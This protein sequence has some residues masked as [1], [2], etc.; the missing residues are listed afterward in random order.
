M[1]NRLIITLLA[2]VGSL[3]GFAD[4]MSWRN[5]P[6][7]TAGTAVHSLF[8]DKNGVILIGSNN[9][10]YYYDGYRARRIIGDDDLQGY[11]IYGFAQREDKL[12]LGT[13]NGLRVSDQT[14]S[15]MRVSGDC[16]NEIRALTL[17]GDSLYIGSLSGLF[18]YDLNTDQIEHS[19]LKLPHDAVYALLYQDDNLYIGT[20]GGLC[21]YNTSTK[22]YTTISLDI[23]D[24]QFVNSL[25]VDESGD[26]LFL[27]MEGCLVEYDL[28]EGR[29]INRLLDG[30]SVKSLAWNATQ[31]IVGTD[32][33][34]YIIK[35]GKTYLYRHNSRNPG[36]LANNI[37]WALLTDEQGNIIAGSENGLSIA[38]H[39][40]GIRSIS[41]SDLTGQP[42]GNQIYTILR[43]AQDNLW[44]GGS[45]GLIRVG[46][47]GSDWFMP[48]D[49]SKYISHNRIRD[50]YQ[51]RSG[52]IW[53]ATDGSINR[54][55]ANSRTFT[56]FHLRDRSNRHKADWAYNIVED[57]S[58]NL[59]VG[60][61]LGGVMMVS[62][63]SLRTGSA[64]IAQ[65][66]ITERS[67]LSNDFVNKLLID[68]RDNKWLL[69]FRDSLLTRINDSGLRH[70]DI[71]AICGNY[72]T[73]LS[74][75]GLDALWVGAGNKIVR[76][77]AVTSATEVFSL[78]EKNENEHISALE[79]IGS[80]VWIVATSG[81]WALD[82]QSGHVR[83]LPLPDKPYTSV[84]YDYL[85]GQV[86][87]GANDEI[88]AV[89]TQW[90]F[91]GEPG[92]EIKV[93]RVL[94]NGEPQFDQS[95]FSGANSDKITLQSA[96]DELLIELSTLEYTPTRSRRFAYFIKGVTDDFVMLDVGDNTLHLP[97]LSPG[98]Y[99][100][101]IYYWD[102]IDTVKR[103]AIEVLRP[104]YISNWAIFA[105]VL[106]L[107]VGT[108][109][110]IRYLR[111]RMQRRL[112]ESRR[113]EAM[114]AVRQKMDF[115]TNISHDLKTP[116]SM[117][118]GPV[119]RLRETIESKSIRKDLNVI[120]SNA[121]K[122]NEMIQRTVEIDR[123]DIEKEAPL[124]LSKVNVTEFCKSI[125]DSY[126][127]THPSVQF[128]FNAD[129]HPIFTEWDAVKIE[130]VINNLLSNACKYTQENATIGFSVAEVEGNI[131]MKVS[132]DG[133]GIPEEE[134][135]L[136]FQRM[137]RSA[138]TAEQQ[139][140]TGI[141]LYLVKHYVE[142][143]NGTVS[144]ESVENF[145]TTFTVTIPSIGTRNALSAPASDKSDK[146]EVA[147]SDAKP[148]ILIVEDNLTIADFIKDIL[149]D[150]YDCQI[151]TNGRAGISLLSTYHPDLIIT[152][153]MMPVMS[154]LEMCKRI[155]AMPAFAAIPIIMVTAKDDN[156]TETESAALGVD[157]F[158]VKP[159]EA[160]L[161]INIV[162]AKIKARQAMQQTLRIEQ[163]TA[164]A[165][166]VAVSPSEKQ[167]DLVTRT[168]EKYIDDSDLNV[169]FLCEKTDF[170]AKQLYRLIKKYV[171]VTPIEYIRQ[172]RLRKAAE[173]LAK[174]SFT[175]SEVMYMVG[176]SSPS[177]FSK[178]FTAL[179]GVPPGKYAE[180]KHSTP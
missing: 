111:Q 124:I 7:G 31:L 165:P 120:Y 11:Q 177:Y 71:R 1:C 139:T 74:Y 155:K 154:G 127:E 78:P 147:P 56:T 73:A 134:L 108:W 8:M 179:Y 46:S 90:V 119:S 159:F 170:N 107:I 138:R 12:Y 178:C 95:L 13:N 6:V 51:T 151:A 64:T 101:E 106:I 2:L 66:C 48:G 140:G 9:G 112:E 4:E 23:K 146:T 132:D 16:P 168:I 77:D 126:I 60:S 161:L 162:D 45:N 91:D 42:D 89:D 19:P 26:I 145:G 153:E 52:D 166:V 173:L 94:I 109:L 152:D 62:P 164:T 144:V 82:I 114:M 97:N 176:F 128:V 116:L 79:P 149:S 157:N 39:V 21:R 37:I 175:V 141:G 35:N 92:N 163:L 65:T 172:T 110:T 129:A 30:N 43:D 136:V 55:N 117:I 115:L 20:Y 158:I 33:G 150:R 118:I 10:L 17:C 88:I 135:S 143:H 27:G 22:E 67:G 133:Y 34:L 96:S 24:R 49:K 137:Y 70:I 57:K 122:I 44:L 160:P 69:L 40:E 85:E 98:K 53:V 14:G 142:L 28:S 25:A 86:L 93:M 54:Y 180:Q 36:S 103:I 59:W 84:Y 5:V 171:G 174:Q 72:P 83:L 99:E 3:L 47:D 87:L 38:N 113:K 63:D 61:Y 148:H 167:L 18:I 32:N 75:D 105:Y 50:I 125:L 130:S 100:L 131:V 58:G 169:N 123:S 156:H 15:F 80:H 41:L 29:I 81:I 104:W 121:I 102:G 68:R 76:V